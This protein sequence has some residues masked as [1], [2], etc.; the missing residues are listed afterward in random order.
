MSILLVDGTSLLSVR[1]LEPAT[2]H[3]RR[4]LAS[5]FGIVAPQALIIFTFR[6]VIF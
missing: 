1:Q 5:R 2:F 6:P 4:L 3:D